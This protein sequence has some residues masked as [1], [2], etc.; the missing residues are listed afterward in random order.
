MIA[1]RLTQPPFGAQEIKMTKTEF[2][3]AVAAAQETF[4]AECAVR[5]E[6]GLFSLEEITAG[7]RARFQATKRDLEHR[8]QISQEN[9]A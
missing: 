6:R 3:L 2:T 7:P 9:A 5:E 1:H 8:L 4:R